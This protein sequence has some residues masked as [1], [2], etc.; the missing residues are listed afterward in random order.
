[1]V[2]TKEKI[3]R[4]QRINL[5]ISWKNHK[6]SEYM[7]Y[8]KHSTIMEIHNNAGLDQETSKKCSNT[9]SYFKGMT[10]KKPNEKFSRKKE[11]FPL[12]C[13]CFSA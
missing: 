12:R 2:K 13:R 10:G 7:G 11:I 9:Q 5:T 4:N 3:T 6:L 1:M 8:N